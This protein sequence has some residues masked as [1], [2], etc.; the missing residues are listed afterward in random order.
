MTQEK[1]NAYRTALTIIYIL[2]AVLMV[3]RIDFWWWGTKIHPLI[4]GWLSLPMIYQLG[5]WA[6]GTVLVF[7]LCIGVWE[8][9]DKEEI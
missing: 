3:V 8:Q 1:G 7:W 9:Q 6:A 5:I 2:S 4:F